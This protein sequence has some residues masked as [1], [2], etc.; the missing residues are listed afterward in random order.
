MEGNHMCQIV[1]VCDSDLQY[2]CLCAQA[3]SA[4]LHDRVGAEGVSD[5]ILTECA[6]PQ[7]Q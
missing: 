2:L 4:E 7:R 3:F 5:L 1:L 6:Q